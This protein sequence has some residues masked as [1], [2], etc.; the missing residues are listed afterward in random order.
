MDKSKILS[1]EYFVAGVPPQVIFLM[2]IKELREIVSPL[3]ESWPDGSPRQNSVAEVS[4]IGLAAYFEAYCKNQ[5]AAIGNIVPQ[6]LENFCKKRAPQISLIDA[7]KFSEELSYRAGSLL[8]EG[9]DFGNAKGINSLFFDLIGLTPFSQKEAEQYSEFLNDRNLLVHHG[10]VFTTKYQE[11]KY[12]KISHKDV[13]WDS[14]LIDNPTFTYWAD[15]LE[16]IV[17]KTSKASVNAINKY[18]KENNISCL[19]EQKKAVKHLLW[20]IDK[21][22]AP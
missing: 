11:Q 6:M 9:Y 21:I 19:D 7:L 15:F 2:E 10:G 16:S 14:L 8:A 1:L 12:Y 3:Q 20:D 13:H 4:L 5:F 22:G 17:R 18:F